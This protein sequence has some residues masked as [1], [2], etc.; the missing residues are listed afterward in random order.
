MK[1]KKAAEARD[2]RRPHTAVS[3]PMP[4]RRLP[5]AQDNKVVEQLATAPSGGLKLDHFAGD[6]RPG[7]SKSQEAAVV[8]LR[9]GVI[10]VYVAAAKFRASAMVPKDKIRSAEA[11]LA[12]MRK[13]LDH[14]ERIK[15]HH[16]RGLAGILGIP[17]DD[18]K[19]LDEWSGFATRCWDAK[20]EIAKIA[21]ALEKDIR[22]EK[23][24]PSA[25]GERKKR[26]RILLE[27]LAEWW[28]RATGKTIAPYVQA[29][30]LTKPLW[31]RRRTP[32]F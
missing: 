10:Q 22:A 27:G 3:I 15:P 16:A 2:V 28:V 11:A 24:K 30:R 5:N 17:S 31:K 13:A 21:I 32:C 23:E 20:L 1:Q 14:L 7:K 8:E 29:K 18:P 9:L 4:P 25:K 12:S 6:L 26:L 19:G